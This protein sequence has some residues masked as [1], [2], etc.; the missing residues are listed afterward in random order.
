M[1]W[2]VDWLNVILEGGPEDLLSFKIYVF[3]DDKMLHVHCCS[4]GKSCPALYYPMYCC[5]P[6]FPVLNY[7]LSL[8]K[9]ICPLSW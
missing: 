8:L 9:L 1:F 6:G 4:V 7:L 3:S 2:L 5:M